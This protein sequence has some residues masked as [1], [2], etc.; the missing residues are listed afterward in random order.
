MPVLRAALAVLCLLALAWPASAPQA[1]PPA[2]SADRAVVGISGEVRQ[3][4]TL[5][6]DKL[7]RLSRVEVKLNDLTSAGDYRGCFRL[8]GVPLADLLELAQVDKQAG[9]MP[10]RIDLALVVRGEKGRAVLSWGEVGHKN[11]A[12]VVLATRYQPVRPHKSCAACHEPEVYQPWQKQLERQ[13]GLPRLVVTG[14]CY[15]DRA[16]ESV[17]GIEVR[18]LPGGGWGPPVD[19]LHSPSFVVAGLGGQEKRFTE[20]PEGPRVSATVKQFGEG[21]GFHG[22]FQASGVPLARVLAAA[23]QEPRPGTALLLSA[24]DG[25]RSLVSWGELTLN[26][27]GRRIMVADRKDGR[28]I[29]DGGRF[30]VLLP[31]DLYA[32]RWVKALARIQVVELERPA[33]ITVIGMGCGDTTLLSLEAVSALARADALAAPAD[34]RKRFAFY[35]QGKP[36]LFDPMGAGKKPFNK[37]GRHDQEAARRARQEEQA[38]AAAK[39]RA[40]LDQGKRVALL[41]WGDPLV[42][43]SWRWLQDFFPPERIRFV[44]GMSAFNAGAAA[45]GRDITCNGLVTISDPFTALEQGELLDRLAGQGATLCVFMG[46]P[47]FGEVMEAVAASYPADTPA[48]V[49]LQ[50]GFSQGEREVR[51]TLGRVVERLAREKE[52]WLGIIFVGPCLEHWGQDTKAE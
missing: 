9:Q 10:K 40:A 38:A 27:L 8:T 20:L 24:P 33:D 16:V 4:L 47:R 5:T 46:M 35:L 11:P 1:A 22:H 29:E 12:E 48:R 51:S 6:L 34:I 31:D 13:V 18:G 15:S 7:R 52:G 44:P 14:D 2:K 50:A 43:G 28:P 3:P 26:P 37:K 42:Y 17:R 41:D 45:I 49:V 39:L 32:D 23:G 36:V 21:K 30:Q 19:E 25:Y